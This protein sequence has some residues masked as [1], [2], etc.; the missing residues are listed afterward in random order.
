[1]AVR[2]PSTARWHELAPAT[3]V[4]GHSRNVAVSATPPLIAL[5]LLVC[6]RPALASIGPSEPT[7]LTVCKVLLFDFQH[8]R[9]TCLHSLLGIAISILVYCTY[10]ARTASLHR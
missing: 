2:R 10:H 3:D 7:L 4:P 1:M 5:R 8:A 9:C 6:L